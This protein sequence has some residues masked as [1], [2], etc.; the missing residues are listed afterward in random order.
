MTPCEETLAA[1]KRGLR[2]LNEA[3]KITNAYDRIDFSDLR[4]FYNNLYQVAKIARELELKLAKIGVVLDEV[5]HTYESFV[6]IEGTVELLS[7]VTD[8]PEG[9]RPEES[10]GQGGTSHIVLNL[11]RSETSKPLSTPQS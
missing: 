6:A 2:Q 4:V 7:G 11:F 5:D 10:N 9:P 8:I 3:I 1:A